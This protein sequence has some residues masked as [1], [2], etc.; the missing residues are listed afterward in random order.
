MKIVITGGSGMVGCNIQ[1]H[2]R[3]SEFEILSPTRQDLDL[4]NEDAVAA[5]FLR[6][7]PDFVIHAAGTV[8]GIQANMA[9]PVRFLTDNLRLGLN[10]ITG[11]RR[12]GVRKLLNIGSSCMY[13]RN[14]ENPLREETILSG[15]LEPT[16]EGYAIAKLASARLCSYIHS[17]DASFL[18]KSIIP[19]NLY[20]RHDKFDP[21]KSHMIPAVVRKIAEAV[22]HELDVVSIWGD[23][24]TRREFMYA[25]DLA[26]FIFC[27]TD[28][29]I[30]LPQY[31]NVGIGRD[32]TIT[33]YY[34]EIAGVLGFK[35]RFSH[36]LS[37]PSGMSQK[38]V[39]IT[40][41]EQFG[42]HAKTTLRDGISQTF[43]F[44]K[45]EVGK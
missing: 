12:A 16:N 7:K 3:A 8:G 29:F 32:Y 20:G 1:E 19:C 6:T 23:G 10:V 43:E 15:D 26:D 13:P 41:L 2:Q 11:A 18:Y 45:G 5:Y 27:A 34:S 30:D 38:L 40:K 33:E 37:K 28:R 25:G 17:E 39:D 24:K 35:G 14:A 22:A 42:W 9:E 21:E 44:Y 4:L 31:M 36:D